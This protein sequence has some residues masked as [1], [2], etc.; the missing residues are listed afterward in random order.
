MIRVIREKYTGD[1]SVVIPIPPLRLGCALSCALGCA[2]IVLL[3]CSKAALGKAVAPPPPFP[4]QSADPFGV[5]RRV[6]LFPPII[7]PR[8]G[9]ETGRL[10]A[11]GVQ[12]I[13]A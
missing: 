9:S 7:P 10:G 1:A 11:N 12:G 6:R 3:L 5:S 8:G 4:L 13:F 2:L